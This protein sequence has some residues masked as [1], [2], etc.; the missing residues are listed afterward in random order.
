MTEEDTNEKVEPRLAQ[1]LSAVFCGIWLVVMFLGFVAHEPWFDEAQAWLLARDNSPLELVSRWLRYEGHPPL[2]YLLLWLPA[3]LGLPYTTMRILSIAIAASGVILLLASN[4]V[5]LVLRWSLPFTYFVAYQFSVVSRSYVLLFPLLIGA[6]LMYQHRMERPGV[7]LALLLLMSH[8]S[9]HGLALAWGLLAIYLFDAWRLER[10]KKVSWLRVPSALFFV[11]LVNLVLLALMLYPPADLSI[12]SRLDLSL[13]GMANV[14]VFAFGQSLFGVGVF[15]GAAILILIC[16]FLLT[17]VLREFLVLTL[18]VAPFLGLYYNLWHEGIVSFILIFVIVLSFTKE[19][20]P[21]SRGER[22]LRSLALLTA[23][24][25][26]LN[27]GWWTL[28]ALRNDINDVYSGSLSAAEYIKS[29]EIDETSLYGAGFSALAIQPY[30]EEN[31]FDNYK[32]PGNRSFWYWSESNPW[33]YSPARTLDVEEMRGWMK[34]MMDQKPDY[35]LVS[36]K[37]PPERAVYFSM[38]REDPAYELVAGFEGRH[39]WKWGV[40][41]EDSYAL[42]RHVGGSSPVSVHSGGEVR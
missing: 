33:F 17:G 5:P 26:S 9:V 11:M 7:F 41:E 35:F 1:L 37:F 22:M 30:F 34:L 6:A 15:S 8:V 29:N 40:S 39:F 24:A 21:A 25:F 38:L 31:V 23:L 20:V 18:S 10:M 14:V 28:E 2:W 12:K 32:I 4:R 27:Q 19:I 13:A 36:L 3:N 16:W 42:F